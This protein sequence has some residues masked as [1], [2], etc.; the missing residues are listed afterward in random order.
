MSIPVDL[1]HLRA[2]TERFGPPYLLS[3][4]DAGRA[5]AVATEAW[6]EGGA[7]VVKLGRRSA[8]NLAAR[9]LVS[10]LW[11]PCEV[12]GYSLIVDGTAALE[13]AGDSLRARIEPTRG[14]LHRP[15]RPAAEL[16][17]GCG[18]DCVPLLR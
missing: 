10:L 13:G 11:P 3:V 15:A 6:W 16:R 4:D 14:V 2:E 12:G 8:A 9:P 17:P 7:L 18:A 1:E 5:H